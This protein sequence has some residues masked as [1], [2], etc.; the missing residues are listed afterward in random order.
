ME[1]AKEESS[2]RLRGRKFLASKPRTEPVVLIR[3]LS[4]QV[5]RQS[6]VAFAGSEL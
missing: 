2:T 1:K 5:K 6:D 4:K 3:D